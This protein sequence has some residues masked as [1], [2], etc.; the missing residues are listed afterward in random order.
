[1][2]APKTLAQW[3]LSFQKHAQSVKKLARNASTKLV[4]PKFAR[5]LDSE[6]VN[7][8]VLVK[9]SKQLRLHVSSVLIWAR[10]AL[11]RLVHKKRARRCTTKKVAVSHLVSILSIPPPQSA[12][13]VRFLEPDVSRNSD[14]R[15]NAPILIGTKRRAVQ[16]IRNNIFALIKVHF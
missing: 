1:M 4:K 7:A 3:A 8:V 12:I 6:R 15:K 14:F 5:P 10:L 16:K 11:L 9:Q 13:S 2:G